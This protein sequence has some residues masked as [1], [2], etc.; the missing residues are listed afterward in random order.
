MQS[1]VVRL[2]SIIFILAALLIGPIERMYAQIESRGGAL[3]L[4]A[5]ASKTA[6]IPAAEQAFE[7]PLTLDPGSGDDDFLHIRR[8][9]PGVTLS[10][11]LP[12]G[13]VV[14]SANANALGFEW[15]EL[16]VT[17]GVNDTEN[18]SDGF[19]PDFTSEATHTVIQFPGG[20]PSGTYVL[21]ANSSAEQAASGL[22]VDLYMSSGAT[23][24]ASTD[25]YSYRLGDS[26][27][28]A[29]IVFADTSAV[30][31]ANV[32]ATV[33][34]SREVNGQVS[35]G[36]FQLAGK[37]DLGN[38]KSRYRYT[39]ML[40]NNTGNS[41]WR[42]LAGA[43]SPD[44]NVR[45]VQ[46]AFAFPEAPGSTPVPSA[47]EILI[48]APT[49]PGFDPTTLEWDVRATSPP[50]TLSLIDVGPG[51][52]LAGDGVFATRF[53]PTEA[54]EHHVSITVE[55]TSPQG[56]PFYR[57][58][59]TG[60]TVIPPQATV[61]GITSQ[62]IDANN[63]QKMESLRFTADLDVV[64]PGDYTLAFQIR[65]AT[66]HTHSVLRAA[67]LHP[68][69]NQIV[70]EIAAEHLLAAGFTTGPFTIHE[71]TLRRDVFG[72]DTVVDYHAT[73]GVTP[74]Y[75]LGD[76]ERG[77]VYF[78]GQA[79]EQALNL[80]GQA[81]YDALRVQAEVALGPGVSARTMNC[82]VS[83]F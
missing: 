8:E 62:G 25:A 68:G 60:F 55:G 26:V 45:M 16:T 53:Q 73:M 70:V 58:A 10:L 24:T 28:V 81:G 22:S 27:T 54:G 66:Q 5:V 83:W 42:F 61:A 15:S 56:K 57:N 35:I 11:R 44:E 50:V 17:A 41:V 6:S 69:S 80:D 33:G 36:S 49:S 32:T 38:G 48:L 71:V 4:F 21:I 51:S 67:L 3:A 13:A 76:F 75:D 34:S 37:S 9:S 52:D 46:G 59:A 18:E 40:Q 78:T 47:N 20:Q 14:T 82:R 63:N 43:S 74:A 65:D 64:E 1:A 30:T 77:S 7:I 79:T 29:A 19:G 23:A 2:Y 72:R 39:A 12:G 31:S